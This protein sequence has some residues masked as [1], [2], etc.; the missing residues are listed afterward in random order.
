MR[1]LFT[2]AGAECSIY[3]VGPGADVAFFFED[4]AGDLL[5]GG[6]ADLVVLFGLQGAGGIDEG[7]ARFEQCGAA[8]DEGELLGGHSEEVFVGEPPAD[9]D[10]AADDAGA[11][12]PRPYCPTWPG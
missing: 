4:E 9:V 11:R 8:A 5:L 3:A 6:V 12:S 2:K 7:A 1:E 10:A